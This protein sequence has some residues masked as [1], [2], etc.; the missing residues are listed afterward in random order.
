[1][2][3][4]LEISNFAIIDHLKLNLLPGMSCITGETGAGKSLLLD[5]LELILARRKPSSSELREQCQLT[6]TF[7]V[8]SLPT[9]HKWLTEHGFASANSQ[10]TT[11]T[12]KRYWSGSRTYS[13][14]NE[15]ICN[16]SLVQEIGDLLLQ[17]YGQHQYY[18]LLN[19]GQHLIWLDDY[20]G[21]SSLKQQV[22][23]NYLDWQRLQA[24]H[25]KLLTLQQN[26]AGQT[27]FLEFQLQ[28]LS[29]IN[30]TSGHLHELQQLQRTGARREQL[31]RVFAGV[32]Q[33][34]EGEQGISSQLN[35]A[36][37][38]LE[39][40]HGDL[41]LCNEIMQLL[42]TASIQIDEA[43]QR[44]NSFLNG[45]DQLDWEAYKRAENELDSIYRL[46]RKYHV[47][48]EQ[49]E[50]HCQQLQEEY[51][52]LS[53]LQEKLDALEIQ[54]ADSCKR[55][56][57]VAKQLTAQR[58]EVAK[59]LDAEINLYLKRL[60]MS[61]TIFETRLVE[62]NSAH[63][64][65]L[66]LES[67]EFYLAVN[68]GAEKQPLRLVASGGELSRINLALQTIMGRHT[69]LP[70][71]IFDEVDSGIGGVAADA[72]A[73]V[74]HDLASCAQV[75]CITHLA[76]IA[77]RSSQHYSVTKIQESSS[78]T[79]RATM[80]EGAERVKEIARMLSGSQ[81]TELTLAHA[82]E[83]L[84]AGAFSEGSAG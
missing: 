62:L 63:P 61:G 83:M 14:I 10:E 46:A 21:C 47:D 79:V 48:P 33:L 30:L 28:E 81:V 31:L 40:L 9:A 36:K 71:M 11:A 35:R 16:Q 56:A 32:G 60:G 77:A 78:T 80:L 41:A 55:Y 50:A 3:L 65:P 57:T 42:D 20:A 54:I 49:L 51:T 27:A 66:G 12:I 4:S 64:E 8:S 67:A 2:L 6:A 76:Q 84:K 13:S 38:E 24:E 45:D 70:T 18:K 44:V 25:A 39:H 69:S 19:P 53:K 58:R 75:I 7:D 26:S 34:L 17:I 74:L 72:V 29:Q 59:Q 23:T 1:M 73:E 15:K 37:S 43:A 68:P 52:N 82:T 5:A 22:Y